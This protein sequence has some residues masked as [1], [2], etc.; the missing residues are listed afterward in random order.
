[1]TRLPLFDKTTNLHRCIQERFP[2]EAHFFLQGLT[3]PET[4]SKATKPNSLLEGIFGTGCQCTVTLTGCKERD[5]NAQY[6]QVVG[7]VTKKTMN[8]RLA[9]D[10]NGRKVTFLKL[11]EHL[12]G[13]K[14]RTLAK[15]ERCQGPARLADTRSPIHKRKEQIAIRNIAGQSI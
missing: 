14:L 12:A 10:K 15:F 6:L 4:V 3:T 9:Q 8:I 5:A 11:F 1:M 7:M 13:Q 2:S